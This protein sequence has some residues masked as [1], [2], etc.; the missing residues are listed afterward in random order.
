MKKLFILLLMAVA[1]CGSAEAQLWDN[2]K[3]DQNF[4][5]GLRAGA[6]ISSTSKSMYGN[7][8]I[9]F[10][11]GFNANINIVKSFSLETGLFY[12]GKGGRNRGYD[13]KWK[14]QSIQIPVLANYKYP[15]SKNSEIQLKGG[16]YIAY[17]H[18]EEPESLYV[19]K[20]SI[21]DCGVIIGT[22]VSFYRRF[23]LGIQYEHGFMD[24]INDS[25]GKYGEAHSRNIAISLGYDF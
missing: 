19:D 10:H 21:I 23:Y 7:S 12:S 9:S 15:V 11:A 13:D 4:T 3:P 25:R 20:K 17:M 1:F 18:I 24:M 22:G 5:F 16:G 14:C 6:N 8:L 2:S